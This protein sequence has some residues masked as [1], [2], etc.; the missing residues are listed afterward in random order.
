MR[1]NRGSTGGEGGRRRHLQR[2]GSYVNSNGI[3]KYL[4]SR[5][6][7]D[8][9]IHV[10]TGCSLAWQGR[11]SRATAPVLASGSK[12]EEDHGYG[13]DI[14]PVRTAGLGADPAREGPSRSR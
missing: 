3:Y 11:Q 4:E 13:A 1:W 2:T 10:G 9:A 7:Q 5:V 6:G 8:S 12:V 14:S